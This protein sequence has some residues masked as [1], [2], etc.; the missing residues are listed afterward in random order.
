MASLI[1]LV[2]LLDIK[3]HESINRSRVHQLRCL[4]ITDM[5]PKEDW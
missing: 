3:S 4:V 2:L 1:A 5:L